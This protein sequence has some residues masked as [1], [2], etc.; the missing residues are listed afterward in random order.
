MIFRAGTPDTARP[1]SFPGH[2]C[3]HSPGQHR[4]DEA[5]LQPRP[6]SSCGERSRRARP[7]VQPR[8]ARDRAGA[9]RDTNGG[10]TGILSGRFGNPGE[11]GVQV[12]STYLCRLIYFKV[13]INNIRSCQIILF[14]EHLHISRDMP[15]SQVYRIEMPNAAPDE[16]R[17][18]VV[19]FKSMRDKDN[20]LR[21]KRTILKVDRSIRKLS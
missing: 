4:D 19:G 16:I 14:R 18:I 6:P 2:L 11:N 13:C 8:H 15:F 5:R 7:Q 10:R 9:T 1:P 17:P 20:I 3:Q 12:I 21:Y